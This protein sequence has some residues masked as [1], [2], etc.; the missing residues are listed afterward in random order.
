[1]FTS[2]DT[3]SHDVC[4]WSMGNSA[5][6]LVQHINILSTQF[7][8][9]HSWSV[10]GSKEAEALSRGIGTLSYCRDCVHCV[11]VSIQLGFWCTQV[12]KPEEAWK[13]GYAFCL[14]NL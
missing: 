3:P 13:P 1:M 10:D 4:G 8:S 7:E 9:T 2:F 11:A 6:R 12:I 14:L 5:C